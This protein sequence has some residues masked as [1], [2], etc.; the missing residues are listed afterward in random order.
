MEH[1]QLSCNTNRLKNDNVMR[2]VLL[3]FAF[4]STILIYAGP[5]TVQRG[6]NFADIARL[7]SI[8]LDSLLKV[9]QGM[10][11]Y[12]GLTIDV[13]I[14]VLVYDL[15]NSALF[16][17]FN[18]K[19]LQNKE[20][21]RKAYLK[22]HEAQGK[23]IV[24]TPQKAS[25]KERKI[26]DFYEEAVSYGD[27]DAL[28]QLGRYLI[29]GR[30]YP[31]DLFPDF[32]QPM[33]DNIN[34]F[35]K[36]IEY[37]QISALIGENTKALVE[38]AL[39]CGNEKSM[40]YN[41]YICLGMLEYFK[42]ELSIPVERLLCQM[43]EEGR[44]ISKDYIK[45]YINCESG[46][47]AEGSKDKTHKEKILEKIESLPVSV[48]NTKY[49]VGLDAAAWLS[50]SYAHYHNDVME[51]EGLFWLH[52]AARA[53]NADANWSL[54]GILNSGQYRKGSVGGNVEAQVMYF[55]QQAADNGNEEAVKYMASYREYQR[56]KKEYERQK[57]LERQREKEERKRARQEKWANIIGSVIQAGVQTYVAVENAKMQNKVSNSSYSMPQVSYMHMTDA[58]WQSRNQLAMQQILQY[59]INKNMADWNGT[60]MAPTD[61]SA[62]DFGSDMTPG[63]ALWCWEQQQ[64]INR[65]ETQT[66]RMRW[67]QIS[68]YRQQADCIERQMLENPLQPIE[69]YIDKDGNWISR[70]MIETDN[71]NGEEHQYIREKN[72][73]YYQQRYGD[74][75]CHSCHGRKLCQTCNGKRYISNP[76]GLS[77]DKC[78][79]CWLKNG[80][81]TGLC[82]NCQGKGTEYGLKN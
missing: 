7:Y 57:D 52:R 30:L 42:R 36:G 81:R 51:P 33:N 65:M 26:L 80:R 13:P 71:N 35:T 82:A 19:T 68:F 40:I 28:Y 10:E 76:F 23:L 14:P 66:G 54:A 20:K 16:R 27:V 9:N 37:L 62:V 11:A 72:R 39:A 45:A 79:N 12:T 43:Y 59:T 4:A 63:G 74:R 48:E 56:K 53:G 15:G 18:N 3:I 22:G 55:A 2:K 77:D 25:Y 60:P 34:E 46:T 75:E 67:E 32:T 17:F 38:L 41:P 70:E 6:E 5:H 24:Y 8:P 29:H 64:R 47:L 1:I 78:P 31:H 73:E 58:Q 44:G 50:F 21:G 69:G 61:M 49:G